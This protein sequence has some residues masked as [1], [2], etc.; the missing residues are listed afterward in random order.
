VRSVFSVAHLAR[1]NTEN[2]DGNTRRT[3]IRNTLAQFH[4][5][6]AIAVADRGE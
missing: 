4:R 2:T 3:G 1:S 6:R 5:I